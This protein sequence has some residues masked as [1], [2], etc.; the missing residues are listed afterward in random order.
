MPEFRS[1]NVRVTDSDGNDLEEW[2][3]QHLRSQDKVSTYIKSCTNMSFMISVEPKLPFLDPSLPKFGH[4]DS[5]AEE[6]KGKHMDHQS[7]GKLLF[8]NL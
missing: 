4:D 8:L 5:D 7:Q 3:V 2:G 6:G 1:L